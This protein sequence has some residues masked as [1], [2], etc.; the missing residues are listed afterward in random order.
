[1]RTFFILWLGQ[2]ISLVGSRVTAFGLSL[3][4]YQRTGSTTLYA[5]AMLA[6]EGPNI[7][8]SPLAGA[9][10]DR[11]R[12]RDLLVITNAGGGICSLYI[13]AM[14]WLGALPLWT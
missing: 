7:V 10:A 14:L 4:V 1:M 8:F 11:F 5:L 9:L 13:A 6:I 2:A 3:W 12:R